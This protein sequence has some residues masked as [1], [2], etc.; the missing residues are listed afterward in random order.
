MAPWFQ[1]RVATGRMAPV[2]HLVRRGALER[3]VRAVAV[4]PTGKS[5]EFLA[6]LLAS[7][8]DQDDAR[9][10]RFHRQDESLDHGD[11]AVLANGAKARLEWGPFR[12]VPGG[13]IIM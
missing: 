12:L 7:H 6:H 5:I 10:K 1:P 2:V 8:G 11:A 13:Y 9:A 3:H 4:V